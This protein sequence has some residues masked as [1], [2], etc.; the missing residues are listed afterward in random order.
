MRDHRPQTTASLLDDETTLGN[1]QQRAIALHKLNSKVQACLQC[2]QACRVS[3]YRQGVLIIEV[4]SAAW[5]MRLNYERNQLIKQLREQMLPQLQ[6]LK[7]TIN[8][9]LAADPPKA[10]QTPVLKR[11]PISD[12]AAAALLK[13]AQ[14]APAKIK[15]R[16]ER[17]AAL[18]KKPQ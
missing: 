18:S 7:V 17:I 2:A 16:L 13:T 8:P 15:A 12:K 11:K 9:S 10:S 1:I 3:N 6:D 14:D 5:S 4:A